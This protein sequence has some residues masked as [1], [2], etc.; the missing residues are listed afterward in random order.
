MKELLYFLKSDLLYIYCFA[1]RGGDTDRRDCR[2]P[3]PLLDAGGRHQRGRQSAP[4]RPPHRQ[5]R[6][7]QPADRAGQR[8]AGDGQSAT[9][10]SQVKI[11]DKKL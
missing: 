7:G 2:G 3:A 5:P 11:L 4:P 1:E 8:R 6:P 9:S 10:P